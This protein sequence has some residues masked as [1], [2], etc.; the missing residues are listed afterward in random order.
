MSYVR[1]QAI[2]SLILLKHDITTQHAQIICKIRQ[3][4]QVNDFSETFCMLQRSK[5][6]AKPLTKSVLRE[7]YQKILGDDLSSY[8]RSTSKQRTLARTQKLL[9]P[10]K[11][12][13]SKSPPL[14]PNI[15]KEYQLPISSV[16]ELSLSV[17]YA[18]NC[19]KVL[20]SHRIGSQL[21]CQTTRIHLGSRKVRF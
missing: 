21:V 5:L 11:Y 6:A 15:N 18:V 20:L 7:L 14:T 17:S 13:Q 16:F 10:C 2:F 19:C 1:L 9:T 8:R 3:K 12:S 4:F